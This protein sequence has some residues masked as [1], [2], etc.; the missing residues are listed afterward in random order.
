MYSV[1]DLYAFAALIETGSVTSAANHLQL[2]PATVSRRLTKLENHLGVPLFLRNTRSFSVTAEGQDFYTNVAEA[3]ALLRAAETNLIGQG[4]APSGKL[5][6]A[7]PSWFLH[8]ILQPHLGVF[9]QQHPNLQLD[10]L[11]TDD[12]I[13][14]VSEGRD[15]GIRIGDLGDSSLKARLL[16]NDQLLL[17]AS[18]AYLSVHGTPQTREDLSRHVLIAHPNST[19][20]CESVDAQPNHRIEWQNRHT[21]SSCSDAHEATLNGMGMAQLYRR[22]VED[23]LQ[24]EKLITVLEDVVECSRVP[25]WFIRTDGRLG[26]PK[27]DVFRNFIFD[28]CI[29][30]SNGS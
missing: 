10:L 14:L 18:P 17:C 27:V 13:S 19:A 23:D 1:D 20:M 16:Y 26:T 8:K 12:A 15:V 7:L 6:I 25:V 30:C 29:D 2:N 21:V 5:R 24:S 22:Q 28:H 3:I 11:T 4:H 9:L